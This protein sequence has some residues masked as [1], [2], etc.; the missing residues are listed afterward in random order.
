MVQLSIFF[1]FPGKCCGWSLLSFCVFFSTVELWNFSHNVYILLDVFRG[2]R[3]PIILSWNNEVSI[4]KDQHHI[5]VNSIL[6][7]MVDLPD[8]W[9]MKPLIDKGLPKSLVRRSTVFYRT[10]SKPVIQQ[11]GRHHLDGMGHQLCFFSKVC[12]KLRENQTWQLMEA[13]VSS[14]CMGW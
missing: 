10:D 12:T 1:L 3:L 6:T 11:F 14:S 2:Y 4:L 9:T 8:V 5:N 7:L 13:K